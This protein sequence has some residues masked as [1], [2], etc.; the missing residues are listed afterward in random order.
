M[1]EYSVVLERE[2]TQ[3]GYLVVEAESAEE[4]EEK[5]EKDF[6]EASWDSVHTSKAWAVSAEKS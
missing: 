3:N 2:I 4:A 5:A 6:A 1:A